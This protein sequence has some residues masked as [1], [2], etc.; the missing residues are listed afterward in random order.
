MA[1]MRRQP[2]S[3]SI[4]GRRPGP[5]SPG[6]AYPTY[7]RDERSGGFVEV[8]LGEPLREVEAPGGPANGLR[9]GRR[10]ADHRR[11]VHRP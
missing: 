7:V 4:H 2:V 9:T 10:H 8:W 5:T 1:S 11:S 6:F 3:R